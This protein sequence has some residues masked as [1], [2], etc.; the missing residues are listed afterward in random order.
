M[1]I[2]VGSGTTGTY[3][4]A[5]GA[6]DL[7]LLAFSRIGLR[8]SDL[9]TQHLVDAGMEANLL[10][11]DVTNRSPNRWTLETQSQALTSPTAVYTLSNRTIGI[12]LAYISTTSGGVTT[13]RV[14][15]PISATEYASI[16]NKGTLAPPTSYFFSLLTTPTITLWP[17]P[18]TGGP[19]TL[20]MLTFRQ[21]Q[22]V[23]LTNGQSVDCPYRFLDAFATGLAARLAEI[24][25][26]AKADR[27]YAQ[28]EQRFTLAASLD[29][30]S[31]PIFIT[32]GLAGY[33]K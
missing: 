17:A 11:V 15:G 3:T 27:L 25:A 14:L 32:P 33:F 5:A 19:Y 21:N 29:A 1:T 31:T 23:D 12:G 26:P 7:V 16:P 2:P 18:D 9:S 10:M 6:G 4:F 24:Y 13:D 22:D 28:Y 30:E 8:R 20:N